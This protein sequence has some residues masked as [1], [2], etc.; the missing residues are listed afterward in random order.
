MTY[1][2]EKEELV[3]LLKEKQILSFLFS[4]IFLSY[5]QIFF[6]ISSQTPEYYNRFHVTTY[7]L[8]AWIALCLGLREIIA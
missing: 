7:T 4:Y 8:E 6:K 1:T 3:E 5:D 2:L